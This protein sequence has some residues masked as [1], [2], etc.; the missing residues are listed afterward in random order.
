MTYNYKSAPVK[1]VTLHYVGTLED[2]SEFDNSHK[3]GQ[4]LT[5]TIG[6]DQMIPGFE[7]NVIGMKLGEK[8]GFTLNPTEAYGEV[9]EKYFQTYPRKEFPDDF[10]VEVGKVINVPA[11]DGNV[12]PAKIEA[13]TEEEVT[14]NFNHPMAGK[15]LTF[16]IELIDVRNENGEQLTEVVKG[17]QNG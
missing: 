10:E 15:K 17:E 3:R 1:I 16:N 9:N 6:A 2:G 13:A 4:P 8:K 14:L 5:F 12:F 11:Q 7:A